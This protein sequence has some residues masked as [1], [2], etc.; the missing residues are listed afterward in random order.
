ML[1]VKNNI[2]QFV[3][4]KTVFSRRI[5]ISKVFR[6]VELKIIKSGFI[7]TWLIDEF[8]V[9]IFHFASFCVNNQPL[10][11]FYANYST[12]IAISPNS[13]HQS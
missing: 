9:Y 1:V 5:Q 13:R 4:S 3:E 2:Q 6:T 8:S 11:A 10:I 12:K 7:Q